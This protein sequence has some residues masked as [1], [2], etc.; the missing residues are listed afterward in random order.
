GE[1]SDEGNERAVISSST[2]I[3][4]GRD[5]PSFVVYSLVASC[6]VG[7]AA[8]QCGPSDHPN[9][10]YW[11]NNGFCDNPGYT[12]AIKQQYCPKTCPNICVATTTV[13]PTTTTT[14]KPTAIENVNC[15]KWDRD[16]GN[17]F[18]SSP[19]ITPLQKRTFCV[20][21]CSFEI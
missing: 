19:T 10:V 8:S 3:T 7:I 20:L 12:L 16:P 18:C 5:M 11:R 1:S 14:Q 6:L 4:K 13:R 9:C 21:T 2:K 17:G 15:G